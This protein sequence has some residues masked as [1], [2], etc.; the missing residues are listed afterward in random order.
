MTAYLIAQS[1]GVSD[2]AG[3]AEYREKVRPVI[4][5]YGGQYLAAG[6]P[7]AKEGDSQALRIAVIAF[8]SMERLN[9]FYDAPE[10]QELKALR[11]RS[12]TGQL[13]FLDGLPD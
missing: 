3:L 12:S 13:L 6:A 9:A 8:P 1:T 2:P 11:Q 4:E 7:D 10:Y 5:A